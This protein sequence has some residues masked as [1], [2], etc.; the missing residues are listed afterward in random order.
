M[1]LSSLYF[2]CRIDAQAHVTANQIG[3]YMFLSTSSEQFKVEMSVIR[4]R[5]DDCC[6]RTSTVDA[7]LV[8]YFVTSSRGCISLNWRLFCNILS[9]WWVSGTCGLFFVADI[10]YASK[11]PACVKRKT[12]GFAVVVMRWFT[13][14]ETRSFP[15]TKMGKV[16]QNLY[17]SSAVAVFVFCLCAEKKYRNVCNGHWYWYRKFWKSYSI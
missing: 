10:K 1:N 5:V 6:F 3:F 9:L 14:R 12:N 13:L 8:Q 4:L 2:R 17:L 16:I 7:L 11:P 15:K